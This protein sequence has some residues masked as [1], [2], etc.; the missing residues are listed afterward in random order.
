MTGMLLAGIV[1]TA[2]SFGEVR[3][4]CPEDNGWKISAAREEL[5]PGVEVLK[6]SLAAEAKR[7]P[8]RFTVPSAKLNANVR[9]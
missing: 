3:L 1:S 4:N 7:N 6:I 5:A 8:P 9:C 2:F